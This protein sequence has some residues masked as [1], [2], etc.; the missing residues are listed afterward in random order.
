MSLVEL[1]KLLA[2]D[3]FG[4][5]TIVKFEKVT[6]ENRIIKLNKKDVDAVISTMTINKERL[7]VVD[8]TSPYYVTGQ[9]ILVKKNSKIR[10]GKNLDKKK[11]GIILGTTSAMNIHYIAPQARIIGFKN[12]KNAFKE[13]EK[14]NIDAIS[15]DATILHGIVIDNPDYKVLPDRYSTEYYGIALR[16]DEVSQNLKIALNSALERADKSGKIQLLE[17]KYNIFSRK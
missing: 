6:P 7:R 11:I 15:T 8:F 3:I 17:K 10:S 13:L 1:I 4:S 16:K 9:A 5:S 2:E 14:E 12:Y